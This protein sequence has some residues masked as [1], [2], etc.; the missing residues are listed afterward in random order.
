VPVRRTGAYRHKKSPGQNKLSINQLLFS[1]A[2]DL[3]KI[4]IVLRLS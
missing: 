1:A 4:N 3:I 2:L